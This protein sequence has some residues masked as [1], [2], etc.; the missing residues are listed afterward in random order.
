MTAMTVFLI[1]L[2]LAML[3]TLALGRAASLTMPRPG[4]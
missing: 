4:F 3:F 2:G 1:W